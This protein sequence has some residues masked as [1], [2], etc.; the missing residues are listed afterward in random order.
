[1]R[2]PGVYVDDA[3]TFEAH[4]GHVVR[5]CFFQLSQLKVIRKSIPL[6]TAK[7]LVNALWSRD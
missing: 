1:M 6:D 5:T 4:T 7:T 2:L 3:M